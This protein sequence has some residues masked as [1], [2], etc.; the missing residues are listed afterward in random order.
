MDGSMRWAAALCALACG[1]ALRGEVALRPGADVEGQLARIRALRASSPGP[2]TVR[3]AGG[4]RAAGADPADGG[5]CGAFVCRRRGRRGRLLG[6][7]R[8][9]PLPGHGAGLVGGRRGGRRRHPAAHGERA[10]RPRGDVAERG[11]L[12]RE[13]RAGGREGRVH[14][15][16][17]RRRAAGGADGRRARA[18][19]RAALPEL[20]HGPF[21]PGGLRRGARRGARLAGLHAGDPLLEHVPAALQA[22]EPARGARRPRRMVPG[23]GKGPVCAARRRGGRDERRRGGRRRE[24]A[25][26]PGRDERVV[27]WHLLRPRAPPDRGARVHQRP[28]A[29][30]AAGRRRDA[31]L[32]GD[33][34]RPVPVRPSGAARAVAG[35][36]HGG[37]A[38][39]AVPVRG[40]G[41]GRDLHRRDLVRQADDARDGEPDPRARQHHPRRR[42][43]CGR[44]AR[45]LDGPCGGCRRGAQR[46]RRLP[47]HGDRLGLA[48]GVRPDA[49]AP[50]PDRLEPHPPHRKRHSERHGR[51]LH[52]GGACGQRDRR[53][54][55]P[56]RLVLWAGRAR[57]A[58]HLRGRGHRAP[59]RRLQPRLRHL[60]RADHPALREGQPFRQQHPRV[61][62]RHGRDGL[63]RP[64]RAAPLVR[65][66]PQHRRLGGRARGRPLLGPLRGGPCALG[67]LLR[68]QRL[69][70]VRR[71]RGGGRV[72]PPRLRGVAEA[73]RRSARMRGGPA[74][75]GRPRPRLR[76]RRRLSGAGARLRAVGLADGGRDGG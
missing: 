18:R 27:P 54:P 11:L 47:L 59:P 22:P 43:P 74:L 55:H 4:L 25:R 72:Q 33:R 51:H 60:L 52:A 39:H 62:A 67:R 38:R 13:G 63:P 9:R 3:V 58:R 5:R 12:L 40:P 53:Q 56:R 41:R 29:D 26:H 30:P 49:D 44:R 57:G 1:P 66:R 2:L 16:G 73:G 48:L 46:N 10:L 70:A 28:G 64:R 17:G 14:G 50:H 76:P 15:G 35:A 36:G 65:L 21:G 68:Q 34:L 7:P 42:P 6:R 20:G 24:A 23:G 71:R 32:R 37:R 8:P 61:L 19:A 69:V 45:R 31:R 75:Q